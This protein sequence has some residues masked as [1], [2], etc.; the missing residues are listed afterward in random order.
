[1]LRTG[2]EPR[3][4]V[5][6]IDLSHSFCVSKFIFKIFQDEDQEEEAELIFT[7]GQQQQQQ[8]VHNLHHYVGHSLI[9]Q[10]TTPPPTF[11]SL[12]RSQ[13]HATSF[14]HKNHKPGTKLLIQSLVHNTPLPYQLNYF[15]FEPISNCQF[16]KNL[17]DRESKIGLLSIDHCSCIV[18]TGNV[19]FERSSP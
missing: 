8:P 6:E 13:P 16:L 5:A 2:F 4:S 17:I 1:M 19:S 11:R 9:K 7:S 12:S 14:Q 15:L 18:H 3:L 10:T